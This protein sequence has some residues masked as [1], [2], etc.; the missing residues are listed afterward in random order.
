MK[1]PQNE[2]PSQPNPRLWLKRVLP[3]SESHKSFS[4]AFVFLLKPQCTLQ[5]LSKNILKANLDC[6][7]P[8]YAY[9]CK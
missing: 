2:S 8:I 7:E 5:S 4:I 6:I 3:G 1:L 9:F